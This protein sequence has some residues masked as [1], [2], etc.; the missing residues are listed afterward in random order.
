MLL[1]LMLVGC[2]STEEL[3]QGNNS[4]YAEVAMQEQWEKGYNLP[5]DEMEEKEAEKD[6]IRMMELYCG[7]Y[8]S[9]AKGS[10]ANVV[11]EDEVIRKIQNAIKESG[12]AVAA[13]TPYNAMEN[14]ETVDTYLDECTKGEQGFVVYYEVRSDGGLN[15]MKF[16]FDG[17]DMYVVSA[18]GSWKSDNSPGLS[19]VSYTRL[20]EWK[21]TSKGWFGYK[22][23][24]PSPEEVGEVTDGS[25]LIRVKPMT[26]Q[27]QELSQRCIYGLGYQ[28]N[29]LL[30]S[31]W[32]VQ[33]LS[34]LDYNGLFEYL[35]KMKYGT[36]VNSEAYSDGIPKAE[37]EKLI[38]EYIPV[39]AAQLQAYGAFDEDR[40][41][42][43]WERLWCFNYAPTYFG[44]SLPEVVNVTEKADGVVALTVEAVCDMVMCDDA[45]ITHELTVQFEKDGSFRY[46]GNTI[47][48]DGINNIPEYQYRIRGE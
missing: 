1:L 7:I 13:V 27:Q 48:N 38:M 14:Y 2:G 31:N 3:Y 23:C 44:T 43:L 37:F 24:V 19:Y 47:L 25:C 10:A 36:E 26:K 46:L 45:V 18:R 34:E 21:Y 28:G 9:V 5:V 39:T 12:A 32:D 6:C 41:V 40:Q 33:H 20:L 29:N 4:G 42:Y 8:E 30:C 35:Y 16:I 11:L 22:L 15:R 17:T